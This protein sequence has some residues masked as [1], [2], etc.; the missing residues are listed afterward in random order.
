VLQSLL[1]Q[2]FA[3]QPMQVCERAAVFFWFVRLHCFMMLHLP[4]KERTHEVMNLML[5]CRND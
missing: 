1:S 4:C 2:T 3:V 5:N